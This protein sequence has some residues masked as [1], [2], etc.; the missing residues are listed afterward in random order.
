MKKKENRFKSILF[1]SLITIASIIGC[2]DEKKNDL[3]NW[4]IAGAAYISNAGLSTSTSTSTSISNSTIPT[5]TLTIP[6]AGVSASGIAINSKVSAIFSE[7][8]DSTTMNNTTFT[9]TQGT[10]SVAGTVS[11]SNLTAIFTPS[12]NFVANTTYTA[13][14]SSQAKSLLGNNLASNFVWTFTTST[15]S[16]ITAPTVILEFPSN[17]ST[18][19]SLSTKVSA[20]FSEPMDPATILAT[21]FTVKEGINSVSG[22]VTFVGINAVFTPNSNL[23]ANTTYTATVT[24]GVLDL[25]GNALANNFIWTFTTGATVD[26]TAPTVATTDP[27]ALETNVILSKK[28]TATFSEAIDISTLTTAKFTLKQGTTSVPGVVNYIGLV[29]TF[30]PLSNL[31]VN[32]TYTA[33]IS[34]GIKDMAGNSLAAD[35]VWTF[36]TLAAK[37]DGPPQV[38]L[39]SAKS[40]VILAKSAVSTTGT[41]SIVGNLGLSPS[42]AT[43]ITGFGLIMDA[44]NVFST[45]SLVTGSIFAANYT[46][47]TPANMTSAVS[48]MELAYTDAAG[49]VADSDPNGY[50]SYVNLGAGDV[51]NLTL[52]PGLYTWS[53]GLNIDN[54]GV[55]LSGGANDVWIFQIAQNITVANTAII[56]LAGGAQSKNVFWQNA[57]SVTIGTTAQFKG[58]ILCKTGIAFNTG[59]TLNGRLLAQTAVT[60]DANAITAPTE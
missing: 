31:V 47:P 24:T 49:R 40:F 48:A 3:E 8:M 50:K 27:L 30:I 42:A 5:V 26:T 13:T 12:S 43:F 45:S 59:A 46:P 51:S 22:V 38:D 9:L 60:L 33:T 7:T 25:A 1:L 29:A 10:T 28:I 16:D 21:T 44:T 36:T 41:T 34:S 55:T 17:T 15:S 18:A 23:A 32:T 53:T 37:A 2:Q 20:T 4:G 39:G 35:K 19:V 58:I 54:R 14:I 56:T 52:T 57:G 11:Y 6:L